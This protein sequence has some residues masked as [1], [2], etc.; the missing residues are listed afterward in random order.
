MLTPMAGSGTVSNVG[1]RSVLS[2]IARIAAIPF[3]V[4]LGVLLL[5]DRAPGL[6]RDGL[7]KGLIV[8]RKV[9][10]RIGIDIVDHSDVPY[11]WEQVGHAG[12]WAVA[13]LVAY[14]AFS[15]R[16]S[17]FQIASGVFAASAAAELGQFFLTA[18]RHL[19]WGDLLANGSGVVIGTVI[20]GVC[21]LIGGR[22]R[23]A[24]SGAA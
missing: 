22:E 5:S 2:L 18:T 1:S 7:N 21:G 4:A 12:L 15:H 17:I 8:G 23:H 10:G 6:T 13:V 19:E 14:A 3:I 16:A 9:E 11:S 24:R 20:A